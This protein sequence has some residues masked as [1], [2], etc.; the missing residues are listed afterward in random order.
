M[1]E[2]E[3]KISAAFYQNTLYIAL[4]TNKDLFSVGSLVKP[5][6][7]EKQFFTMFEEILSI[8]KLIDYFKLNEKTGL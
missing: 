4:H 7:D 5:V 3:D 2:Q 6:C 8:I 1:A